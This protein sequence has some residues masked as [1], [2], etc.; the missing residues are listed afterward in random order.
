[1]EK[2]LLPYYEGCFACSQ[3]NPHGLHQRFSVKDGKVCST[4][5]PSKRFQGYENF[6]HGG[7]FS[8]ILDESMGWAPSFKFGK[9]CKTVK[10]EIRFLK[11]TPFGKVYTIES[12]FVR[13][14]HSFLEATGVV[15]DDE[16]TIYVRGTGLYYPLPDEFTSRAK[17]YLTYDEK[18]IRV[19]DVSEGET[20]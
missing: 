4:F 8:A 2:N 1:M 6:V 11:E 10:L 14:V 15:R 5:E 9:L 3:S 18:T 7:V 12:E 17:D 19:F 13:T 20:R 16:G